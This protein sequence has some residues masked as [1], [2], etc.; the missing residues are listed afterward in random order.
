MQQ[1]DLKA[2]KKQFFRY[3][4]NLFL[5]LLLMQSKDNLFFKE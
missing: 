5:T 4:Q 3:Q 2:S 1:H